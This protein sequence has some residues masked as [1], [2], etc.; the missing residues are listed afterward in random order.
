M[1]ILNKKLQPKPVTTEE[2]IL[3]AF[4]V[5]CIAYATAWAILFIATMVKG[6]R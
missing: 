4:L 1:T 2:A 3:A 5:I 6:G